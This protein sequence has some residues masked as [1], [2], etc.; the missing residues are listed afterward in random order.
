MLLIVMQ[1][2]GEQIQATLIGRPFSQPVRHPAVDLLP[3]GQHLV[4]RRPGHQAALGAF[5]PGAQRLI[6]AVEQGLEARIDGLITGLLA[7][8]HG[9]EEPAGVRQ[10]PFA[11]AAI[12]HG[13]GRQVLGAQSLGQNGHGGADDPEGHQVVGHTI[14]DA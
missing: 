3:V 4:Q 5:D 13:L 10:V 14:G 1:A 2:E 6:I 8:D 9:L 11:G 12:G 7:Q